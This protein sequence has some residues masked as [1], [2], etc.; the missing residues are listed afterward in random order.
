MLEGFEQLDQHWKRKEKIT[1]VILCIS[2]P[3][4][5]LENKSETVNT[6]KSRKKMCFSCMQKREWF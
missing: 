1:R 4:P 2:P 5:P 3:A 6:T